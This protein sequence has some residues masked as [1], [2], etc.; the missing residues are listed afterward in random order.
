MV[1]VYAPIPTCPPAEGLPT[2]SF[3]PKAKQLAELLAVLS[4]QGTEEIMLLTPKAPA[5]SN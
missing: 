4:V 1:P 5:F 3:E 2:I